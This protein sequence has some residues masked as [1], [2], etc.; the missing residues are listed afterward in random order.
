MGFRRLASFLAM[1]AVPAIAFAWLGWRLIDMDR[2]TETQRV[3]ERLDN[4]AVLVAAALDRRLAGIEEQLALLANGTATDSTTLP[5]DALMVRFDRNGVEAWPPQ[6]LLYYPVAAAPDEAPAD[7]FEHGE[8]LEFR[9][10]DLAGAINV[11]RGIAKASD[12]RIRAD[13][14]VRVARNLR[15]LGRYHEALSVYDELERLGPVPI[16]GMPA[17]L[18][19]ILGRCDISVPLQRHSDLLQESKRLAAGLDESRWVLDRDTYWALF[20]ERKCGLSADAEP[21][22]INAR[23]LELAAVVDWFWQEW[24]G[25]GGELANWRGRESVDIGDGVMLAVWRGGADRVAAFIAGPQYVETEWSSD[26]KDQNVDLLLLDRRGRVFA[27]RTF[28]S[29]VPTGVP[30]GI[31]N[32]AAP[33]LPWTLTVASRDPTIEFAEHAKRRPLLF[34]GLA[35][36]ALVMIIGGYFTSRATAR[37]LAVARLQSDFVSTVSHEFRTPLTSM[38][39]LTERLAAGAVN[40]T[41]RRSEYY[42]VLARDT[43]RLHRLVEGLLDFGRMEAGRR[44]YRFEEIDAAALVAHVVAEFQSPLENRGSRLE[45]DAA[46]GATV[47]ADAEALALA[48]RNL[49]DNALKYSPESSAVHVE[50]AREAGRLA[51]RIRDQGI[52]IPRSEQK[53]IFRKFVRGAEAKAL[54][55]KGTGIGLA[56]AHHIVSAHGGEIRVE[57]EPGRGSTFM[58]LL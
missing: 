48:I 7:A 18:V 50:L 35:M 32:A 38:R 26:W 20:T 19:A 25:K 1:T 16:G 47:R 3:R 9:R 4:A 54:S 15:Q 8:A 29:G 53:R 2:V 5:N 34:A 36:I 39:H 55:I 30:T 40:S 49:I 28:A 13:A 43:E 21:S 52:G 6:H 58:I 23:R 57:S 41:E 14:L 51:I 46:G 45:F 44:E 22:P 24:R 11:Y 31:P 17:D 12:A 33:R 42:S 37:E 27:G 10:R 56:M